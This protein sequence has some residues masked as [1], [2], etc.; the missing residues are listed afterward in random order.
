M[1]SQGFITWLK[2]NKKVTS[3]EQVQNLLKNENRPLVYEG[4]FLDRLVHG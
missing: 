1:R 3:Q 4:E 2:L